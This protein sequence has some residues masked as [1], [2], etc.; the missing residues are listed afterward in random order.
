MH[1]SDMEIW[2]EID[3]G[4]RQI[5]WAAWLGHSD[6]ADYLSPAGLALHATMIELFEDFFGP[7]WLPAAVQARKDADR[8]HVVGLGRFSP[9]FALVEGGR[10]GQWAEALRWWAALKVLQDAAVPGLG[11]VRRNTRKDVTLS[12]TLHTL[13]QTRLAVLGLHCGATVTLEPDKATGPGDVLLEAGESRVFIE[14]VTVAEDQIFTGQDEAY[15][16]HRRHLFALEFRFDVH[17]LGDIPGQLSRND[18]AKWKPGTDEAAARCIESLCEVAFDQPGGGVLRVRPGKAPMGTTLTGPMVE[19]DQGE[20]LMGKLEKRAAQSQGAGK[21]WS[22]VRAHGAFFPHTGFSRLP[23]GEKVAELAAL[24]APLLDAYAHLAGIV[25]T[26][27]SRRTVPLPTP[28]TERQ[29]DG[30]GLVRGI[31]LDRVRQ[32]VILNPR[33]VQPGPTGLVERMVDNEPA[34]LDWAL[35]RFGYPGGLSSLLAPVPARLWTPS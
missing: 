27:A 29:R 15:E 13:A 23:L 12:K 7:K 22:W 24:V 32:T 3:N 33:I 8:A 26:N 19:R 16:N 4:I 10:P 6:G 17:W 11:A 28:Q 25:Y 18:A 20:R 31:P 34:W 14:V 30:L 9:V 21:A 1:E 35:G 5:D 2:R